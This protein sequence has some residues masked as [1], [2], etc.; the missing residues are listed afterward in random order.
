LDDYDFVPKLKK[1][2]KSSK[3]KEEEEF[4]GLLGEDDDDEDEQVKLKVKFIKQTFWRTNSNWMNVIH[5]GRDIRIH[6]T[7]VNSPICKVWI[8]E[9]VRIVSQ[10]RRSR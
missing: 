10:G 9:S 4:K 3:D 6:V 8:S 2:K 1:K 5:C 7:E